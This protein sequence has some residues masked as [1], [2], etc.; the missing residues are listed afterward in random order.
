MCGLRF[1]GEE[2]TPRRETYICRADELGLDP[3]E[4]LRCLHRWPRAAIAGT[5]QMSAMTCPCCCAVPCS[6]HCGGIPQACASSHVHGC[7]RGLRQSASWAHAAALV[8]ASPRLSVQIQLLL[9]PL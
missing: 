9:A 7:E 1:A 3:L 4:W 8:H 2:E 6:D 5:Q